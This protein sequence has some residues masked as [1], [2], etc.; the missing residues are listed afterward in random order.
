MG[1]GNL[2][3]N[4]RLLCS[5]SS[6]VS[7][8]CRRLGVN[9]HQFQKY[10]NGTAAPSLRTLRRISD[11]FGV[12]ESEIL[13]DTR[14]FRQMIAL[15]RP[16]IDSPWE[17]RKRISD[18]LFLGPQNSERLRGITGLYHNH[19]CAAEYPGHVLR[20][21][22][23][24]YED[25]GVVFSK[26]IERNLPQ[27]DRRMR[28]YDGLLV[29]SGDRIIMYEREVA[30]GKMAWITI[31]YQ[32]DV[33]QPDMLLGLSVG[34]TGTFTRELACYRVLL[35]RLEG[36]WHLRRALRQCGVF[37]FGDPQIDDRIQSRIRN[38]MKSEDWAFTVPA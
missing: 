1:S 28:K 19:F 15:K 9:R 12:E 26:N 37:P 17:L 27:R 32:R 23:Y 18:L 8:V 4:L 14:D 16:I 24:I 6:S 20:G 11:Y 7:E 35:Q 29:S 38:E 13:L 5:Y 30:V 25:N 3:D 36:P 22:V 31:Y 21:L 10:L 34:V 33:D 2:S